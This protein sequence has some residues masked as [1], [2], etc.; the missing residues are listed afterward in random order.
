MLPRRFNVIAPWVRARLDGR[1]RDVTV[2]QLARYLTQRPMRQRGFRYVTECRMEDGQYAVRVA[3][4]DRTLYWPGDCSLDTLGMLVSE[5]FDPNDWHYYQVPDTP[6]THDD[7]VV[8]CGAAEG[9]FTLIASR[10]CRKVYAVEPLPEFCEN[11]A[12]SFA[13]LPHVQIIA[14]LLAD[15]T[16]E[17]RLSARAVESAESSGGGIVCR[18]DALDNLFPQGSERVTYLKAD[19][20]GGE[21]ALLAGAEQLIRRDR[22]KIAITTYH[23]PSHADHITKLLLAWNPRYLIRTKGICE[24]GGPVMLHARDA[25]L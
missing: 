11:L 3:G 12:R 13:G 7:V 17:T 22:P 21:L 2:G 16:G 14:C 20:E 25:T 6:L 15:R 5:Q 1:C 9:L 4:H 18:V 10:I 24:H 8:D 23:H 19:V